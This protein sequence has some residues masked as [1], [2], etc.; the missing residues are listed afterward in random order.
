MN[1]TQE[2]GMEVK[3]RSDKLLA[4]DGTERTK[5]HKVQSSYA[6]LTMVNNNGTQPQSN[7]CSS[8]PGPT[9]ATKALLQPKNSSCCHESLNYVIISQNCIYSYLRQHCKCA[10]LLFP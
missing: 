4:L 9:A 10:D 7:W 1:H 6:Q 2:T 5:I 3:G 8:S